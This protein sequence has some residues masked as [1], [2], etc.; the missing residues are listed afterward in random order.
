MVIG[1]VALILIA[2]AATVAAQDRR[3][4][5]LEAKR[6]RARLTHLGEPTPHLTTLSDARRRWPER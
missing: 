6:R 4:Q 1:L 2:A 3:T 5:Q